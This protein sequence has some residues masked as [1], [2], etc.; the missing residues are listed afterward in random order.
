MHIVMN[1]LDTGYVIDSSINNCLTLSLAPIKK[2]FFIHFALLLL[3]WS[4]LEL[5][6]FNIV[7][8][9]KYLL[10]PFSIVSACACKQLYKIT[11]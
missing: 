5:G 4:I 8:K 9:A 11:Y 1:S 7:R 10:L 2:Q 6:Y 3:A